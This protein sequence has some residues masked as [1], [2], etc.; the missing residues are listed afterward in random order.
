MSFDFVVFGAT[1]LQGKIVSK[2]L[3]ENGYSVLLC[4]RDKSRVEH[5]LKKYKKTDFEYVDLRNINHATK[6]LKN[7]GAN[8]SI[9]CAEED[10]DLNA[11][12]ACIRANVH[13]LDLG[14][15]IPMTIQQLNM[16]SLLAKKGLIHITGC[17]SVP[18]IGNV[19]LNYASNKFDTIDTIEVGYAW[20]S[21]LKKFVVP[22]SIQTI[23]SEFTAPATDVIKRKVVKI[24]PLTTVTENHD[25]FVGDEIEFHVRHPETYTF[26]KYFKNKGLKN[27]KFYAEFPPHSFEKVKAMLDLGLGSKK[28]INFKGMKIKP[29]EFLTEVLKYLPYPK[30]YEE[31]ED[32]WIKV[33]GKKNG[34]KKVS[35]MNCVAPTLK[36]WEDAGCNIDT[37]MPASIMAQMIK[38]DVIKE[39]GSFAPEAVIPPEP[40]FKELRK[41]KMKVYENGKL[42]N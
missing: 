30:G 11:L 32:L 33:Y 16:H 23:L 6:V 19:M 8:V 24:V 40:F 5:L 10:W 20:N 1:G 3:L 26:Y 36:G 31:K 22:F 13:S 4:G 9:T 37:G 18:G 17:G 34:K 41:R 21:N 38:N 25:K 12:K 14:S 7:S 35:E 39:K 42:I 15:E 27:I 2:D 29:V 28:E